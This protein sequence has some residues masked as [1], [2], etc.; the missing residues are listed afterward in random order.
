MVD[1]V[2]VAYRLLLDVA[3][4]ELRDAHWFLHEPRAVGQH[5]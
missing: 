5:S 3:F 2:Y 1:S 4:L